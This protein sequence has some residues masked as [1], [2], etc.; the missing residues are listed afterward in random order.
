MSG[1]STR[2]PR[3]CAGA[4]DDRAVRV[5]ERDV[6]AH[7]DELVGEDQAVLEH[8]LVDQHRALALGRQRDGD[9]RQVGR[10]RR[11]RAVLDLGLVLADVA[12]GDQLSG[13]RARSRRRRRARSAGP[14]LPKTSRIIRR[15]SGS[16]SSIRSSPPVTPAS[17]MNEPISMW[18]GPTSCVQP[19]S[20]RLAGDGQHVGA[21]AADVGAHL[22]QHPREVLHVGLAGGVADHRLARRQRGGHQRVLGRHHRRLVHE[23]VA[24]AQPAARRRRARC[25]ASC[26]KLAPSA[27][28]ASR[29]GSRRRRPITSPPGG[30]MSAW[31]K[32]ASSGPA[33]R[34]EA[35]MRS[36][37]SRS[38]C[39]SAVDAGGAQRDARC[40][41]ATRRATPMPS[42]HA[43]HRLDV[44]DA[45]HVAH[46]DLV[47]REDARRRGSAARRS[48]S[49]RARRCRSSGTP[50]SMTNFSMTEVS[51]AAGPEPGGLARVTAMSSR[52]S[53]DEAWDLL[54]EWVESRVPA[55]PLPGRRGVDARLRRRSGEDEE[56]WGVVGLL[57][58]MDYERHPDLETGHPRDGDRRARGARRRPRDRAR[59]RLARRLPRRLARVDA[60]EDAVRGRRAVAASC[61]PAP[62]CGPRASTG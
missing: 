30:G 49:R 15:S 24:G 22:D 38:T 7:Q 51:P 50:P 60:G 25:R 27:R 31:P 34:N 33:S 13:R 29:C 12:R 42:Q 35:R 53:R 61:W 5:A 44:A 2:S 21:D 11:P 19:P 43:Q 3:S 62:T 36:A 56:L 41:R 54:C 57:H 14:S 9:R 59:D 26:S 17:A 47:G 37:C 28:K 45:R 6:G 58:D 55:P 32:R 8:P 48:C 10:E 52:L 46:D 40:R 39:A 1:D 20:S 4:A 23:D 18:S 16:V